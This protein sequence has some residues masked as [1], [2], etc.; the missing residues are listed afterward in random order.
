VRDP[1][2]ELPWG[3]VCTPAAVFA[4]RQEIVRFRRSG[5]TASSTIERP[6]TMDEHG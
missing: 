4:D 5:G 1:R 2:P 3:N 6:S